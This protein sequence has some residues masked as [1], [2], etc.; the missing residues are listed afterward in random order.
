MINLLQEVVIGHQT[1]CGCTQTIQQ[2]K[3]ESTTDGQNSGLRLGRPRLELVHV[4]EASVPKFH[5]KVHELTY[6][7]KCPHLTYG[8]CLEQIRDPCFQRIYMCS[9]P[10]FLGLLPV[11]EG[12][13]VLYYSTIRL[14]LGFCTFFHGILVLELLA[15]PRRRTSLCKLPTHAFNSVWWTAFRS[16][17]KEVCVGSHAGQ[18]KWEHWL[19]G[20]LISFPHSRSWGRMK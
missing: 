1:G 20:N 2:S 10:L 6:E 12:A 4:Q 3:Y 19:T 18:F 8:Y 13:K 14:I 17:R 15:H 9:S 11:A 7:S 16:H 5:A